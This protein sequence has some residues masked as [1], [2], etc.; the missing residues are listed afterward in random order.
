MWKKFIIG[1]LV[2]TTIF[3]NSPIGYAAGVSYRRSASA[4]SISVQDNNKYQVISPEENV[5]GIQDKIILISGKAPRGTTV[6][7]DAY[8]TT[9]MTRSNFNLENLP[10]EKDY[11]KRYS[12]TI[13]IGS[14]EGFSKQME[15]IL[16]I[17]KIVITFKN[18][19]DQVVDQRIIYVSDI[20]QVSEE[21]DKIKTNKRSDTVLKSIPK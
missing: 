17:N 5:S 1:T 8:G 21:V 19:S 11:I 6:I 2:I 15:L 9:D 4:K 14:L 16:G 10:E 7:I 13:K 20:S 12:E 18:E 3:I